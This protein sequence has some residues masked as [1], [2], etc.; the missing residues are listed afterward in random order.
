MRMVAIAQLVEHL[1]VVQGVAGSSPVIHPIRWLRHD[2]VGAIA[3]LEH[4]DTWEYTQ[5]AWV[6][7]HQDLAT[8]E[9]A[10]VRLVRG[11]VTRAFPQISA[12]AGRDDVWVMGGG[13]L[14]GQFADADLLDEVWVQFAPVTLGTGR[15]LLPR[16]LDLALVDVV[17]N[18]D[19]V[20]TRYRV[21]R[22]G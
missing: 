22:T 1:V 8:P 17:R 7:T 12:S 15:P 9:D 14:A 16:E 2:L 13:D 6:F 4:Q 5:P 20:C 10:D 18:R 11:D 21:A 3:V 19:F